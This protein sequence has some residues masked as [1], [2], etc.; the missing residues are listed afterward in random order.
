MPEGK[1]NVDAVGWRDLPNKD[2]L[3]LLALCR[4]SEPLSNTC[5]LPYI[6]YLMRSVLAAGDDSAGRISRL[7]GVL[8]AAFPLAQCATSMLWARF[9]DSL[10]RRPAVVGAL[11]VSA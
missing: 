1:K 4:L 2:Q 7:S 8:V 3:F 10:G 5:L 11:L 6:F 9:A